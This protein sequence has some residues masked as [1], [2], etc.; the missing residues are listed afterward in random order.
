MGP[1]ELPLGQAAAALG[2]LDPAV[3]DLRTAAS[4]LRH[5]R[6]PRLRRASRVEL[7]AALTR[8]QA[9]G[10]RDGGA[11]RAG[12]RRARGRTARMVP[13]TERI[14]QLQGPAHGRGGRRLP[15]LRPRE[16]SRW[17]GWFARGLTNKQ[18]GQNLYVSEATAENHVQ[19]I[20]TKL[21]LAT[22]ARSPPG[23]AENMT[24]AVHEYQA[25]GE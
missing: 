7:A 2:H 19:H 21:G 11:G 22:A 5:Q 6:R 18:I 24:R 1:V 10:D 14:G 4:I 17:P 20:L 12:H 23:P 3:E 25:D 8:R 13:F 9:R 16:A 15:P